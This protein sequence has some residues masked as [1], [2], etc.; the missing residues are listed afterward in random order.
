MLPPYTDIQRI[1]EHYISIEGQD[2]VFSDC[3]KNHIFCSICKV[4]KWLRDEIYLESTA[5]QELDFV[6][7]VI[8]NRMT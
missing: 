6:S 2:Y 5:D 8:K 3:P 7:F 1:V 4:S